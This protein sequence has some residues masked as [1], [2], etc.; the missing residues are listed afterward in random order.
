MQNV[1]R[2]SHRL[3][4]STLDYLGLVPALQKLVDEFSGRHGIAIDFTHEGVPDI[5]P[6][7]VSLCLFRVTEESLTNMGKHSQAV[8][9]H[10]HLRG[11]D[12]GLVLTI[13]DSGVGFDPSVLDTR[14]GLGFVSM[15]ERLRV[16]H[17]TLRIESA[18]QRGT[19]IEATI[20]APR[21]GPG[22]DGDD[23]SDLSERS[24]RLERADHVRA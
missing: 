6:S 5:L 19:R 21:L 13:R 20:P 15:R 14:A 9:G 23:S 7:D 8:S 10:V 16:L 24:E 4:S 2:L 18:P 3:H 1:H 22:A 17:G 11:A 12:D